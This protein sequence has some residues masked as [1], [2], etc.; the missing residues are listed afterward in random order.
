MTRPIRI[1]TDSTA[2]LSPE[3]IEK[4]NITV[5]PLY[6]TLGDRTYRDLVEINATDIFNHY[7]EYKEL[8]KTAAVSVQDYIDAFSAAVAD[9]FDVIHLTISSEFSAC[10]QNARLAA[11]E[12]GHVWVVDS[13]NLSTGIGQLV[14]MA[15]EL[16]A[17]GHSAPLIA[18]YV[19]K[20]VGRVD[21]SFVLSSL[22]FLY[23]G[24][25][26]SGVAALGANLLQLKPCIEVVNGKMAVG[27][28]YRGNFEKCCEEY[29]AD[30]LKDRDDIDL[31]RIFFTWTAVDPK[32]IH[33]LEKKIRSYQPFKEVLVTEAGST[34]SGHCGPCCLGILYLHKRK[35][36]KK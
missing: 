23:K 20:S 21:S 14:L 15:A 31:H 32:L 29:I 2:D 8:P 19:A 30:R 25:R 3:L 28:K 11:E 35:D 7:H 18:D 36:T 5:L 24:G 26:C 16:A 17:R 1:F 4:F 12:V 27:K 34:I 13:R 10:Y 22:E 9:G 33:A 6:I